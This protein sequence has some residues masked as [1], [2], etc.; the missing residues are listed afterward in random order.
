MIT[1]NEGV[2][3][4]TSIGLVATFGLI[5][6][7]SAMGDNLLTTINSKPYNFLN[8]PGYV[9][10]DEK[11]SNSSALSE[12]SVG[13]I[14]RSDTKMNFIQNH[15]KKSV[16]LE[17]TKISKHKSFFEFEEEYEEI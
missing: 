6:M 17:I 5:T 3:R 4:I 16:K 15:K 9:L 10:T 2:K 12:K 13:D 8:V 14:V 7:S 11:V 1:K